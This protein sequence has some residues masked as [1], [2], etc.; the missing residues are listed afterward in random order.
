MESAPMGTEKLRAPEEVA[1]DIQEKVAELNAL[2]REVALLY[3]KVECSFSDNKAFSYGREPHLA[4]G[5]YQ[6]LCRSPKEQPGIAR[7]R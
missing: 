5:V 3:L 2:F 6:P 1:S 4:I 7:H